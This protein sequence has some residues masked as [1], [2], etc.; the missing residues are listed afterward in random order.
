MSDSA[1]RMQA[2][3]DGQ[4]NASPGHA[5]WCAGPA[6]HYGPRPVTQADRARAEI[7][8]QA[9]R[10]AAR[11]STDELRAALAFTCR[12]TTGRVSRRMVRS[13]LSRRE[14]SR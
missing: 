6:V 12:G 4:C 10:D 2:Q 1:A 7:R 3:H 8:R 9:Y 14:R 13:M 11:M 5:R